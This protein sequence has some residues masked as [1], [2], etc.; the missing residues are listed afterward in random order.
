MLSFVLLALVLTAIAVAL[1]VVPL[2]RPRAGAALP[3]AWKSAAVAGAVVVIGAATL[4]PVW[5]NF[6]WDESAQA[7]DNPQSMVSRLARRLEKNPQDVE[8]WVMLGRSYI[9]L[10]QYPLAVRA[11]ERA[12][13]VS[14]GKDAEVLIGLVE[15]LV[16]RDEQELSG[17]AGEL[18][19]QALALQPK[20]P[21]ALF[22]GAAAALRRGDLAL[23][24][25]RFSDL[26]ALNPPENVK[27]IL[28]QQIEAID[29]QI[30][31]GS[32]PAA[33][34][35]SA[36]AAAAEQAAVR[37]NVRLSPELASQAGESPLFV[38]VRDPSKPGPP[39]AAK[40]L[41]SQFPQQVELTSAD[42]MLAGRTFAAGQQV[43]VEARI[44]R[45]GG[46]TAS[47]GDPYGQINYHVGRDGLVDIVIDRLKP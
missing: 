38:I 35:Q 17:R 25:E 15:A 10:E 29:A 31:A 7:E 16:M 42:A 1:I 6:D 32:T 14:G 36:A 2:V 9:V 4:Y 30:A 43:Q 13:S 41:A 45:S 46:A 26:L 22:Y 20:S 40:R 8:G 12:N 33:P 3:P 34:S 21:K 19:E 24:R 28:R 11:F 5:S 44:S 27:P 37:V 39:L 23:A 47:S 18:L